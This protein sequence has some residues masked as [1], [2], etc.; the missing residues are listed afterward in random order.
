MAAALLGVGMGSFVFHMALWVHLMDTQPTVPQP[1]KGLIYPLNN[2]GWV[3]YLSATQNT[4]LSLPVC[5]FFGC[6]VIGAVL[7]SD[8]AVRAL[9]VE[10]TVNRLLSRTMVAALLISILILWACSHSLASALVAKGCV[11]RM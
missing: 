2:H 10:R 4:Q 11:L 5:V 7:V 6:F 8:K 1:A 3:C 9:S